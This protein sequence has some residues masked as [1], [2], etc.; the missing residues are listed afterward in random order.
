[1][2]EV[3]TLPRGG[4]IIL[5]DNKILVQIGIPPETIKDSIKL[6]GEAPQYFIIPKN[7]F[8]R[9]TFLNVAEVEFPIY[10]NYFIKRRKTFIICT[11]EQKNSLITLFKESLIGPDYVYE[12]DFYSGLNCNISEEMLFFRRK[13]QTKKDELFD[14]FDSVEFIDINKDVRIENITVR[15]ISD[16]ICFFENGEVIKVKLENELKDSLDYDL[17]IIHKKPLNDRKL[18]NFRFPRFG[19]TCLGASNGFDPNGTT[20]GFILWINGKGIFIDPPAH[21]FDEI[22][23]NNIPISSI[24]AIILTHCHADHDAGTLQSMLRGSK[25]RVYTTRTVWESFKRKYSSLLGVKPEFFDNICEFRPIRI[26]KEINIEN[27]I[28]KFHYALHSIPTVGFTVE[29][30]GKTLFY[31]SDTFVSDRTKLLLDEG[32]IS[33]ERYDFT[34]NEFKKYDYILHEAGNGIIHTDIS[35]L[36]FQTREGQYVYAF[37]CPEKEYLNYISSNPNPSLLYPHQ[38]VEGSV[39]ILPQNRLSKFDVLTSV[40]LFLD[41]PLRNIKILEEDSEFEEYKPGE[42]IIQEGDVKNKD[43]FIIVEGYV[44]LFTGGKLYKEYLAFDFFGESAILTERGRSAT[45]IAGDNGC[46]VLRVKSESFLKSIKGTKLYDKLLNLAR[47]RGKDTWEI[48]ST[49]YFEDFT[50]S[51]KTY[52]EMILNYAEFEKGNILYGSGKD[53]NVYIL[54]DGVVSISKNSSVEVLSSEDRKY[55]FLGDPDH[56][57]LGTNNEIDE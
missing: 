54:I 12:D 26:G 11:E 2:L 39:V 4:Y 56:V 40:K 16:R 41:L 13:D 28:F 42:L 48:F 36:D 29:F 21:S 23:R 30:E 6:L 51:M 8:D 43:F 20:S 49:K 25:E 50:P 3:L 5:K 34:M 10:Y 32:I 38:G 37:H 22:E 52:F 9:T 45:I 19:F 57:L 47:I 14:V 55:Y 35:K 1:M 33:K 18:Y 24:V 31:S 17:K 27:A 53:A 44:K 15:K 46:K 7:L